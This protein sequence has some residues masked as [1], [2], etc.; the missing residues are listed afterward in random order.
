MYVHL[1]HRRPSCGSYQNMFT[2]HFL[3][4]RLEPLRRSNGWYFTNLT[5]SCRCFHR[6]L[7]E[8]ETG[9]PRCF[10]DF[11]KSLTRLASTV[12]QAPD[13]L[14]VRTGEISSICTVNL[15][16]CRMGFVQVFQQSVQGVLLRIPQVVRVWDHAA[17]DL[18]ETETSKNY[19]QVSYEH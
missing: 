4:P 14:I 5:R 13:F 2:D 18:A 19:S 15:L 11:Q 1:I 16:T 3:Y 6:Q 8:C 9:W 7:D 10:K 17:L 12:A